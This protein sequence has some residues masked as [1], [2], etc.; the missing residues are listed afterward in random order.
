MELNCFC[1]Y[2]VLI[3]LLLLCFN[4]KNGFLFFFFFWGMFKFLAFVRLMYKR[5]NFFDVSKFCLVAKKMW[6]L[7]FYV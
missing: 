6:E 1:D 5:F 3:C 4:K 2:F 7:G